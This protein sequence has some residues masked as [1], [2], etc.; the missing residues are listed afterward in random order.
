MARV[1]IVTGSGVITV[2]KRPLD[3]Y[4]ALA[5]YRQVVRQP[6]VVCGCEAKYDIFVNLNGGGQSGQAGAVRHGIARSLVKVNEADY[7]KL[8]KTAGLLTR[9]PR[10]KE[11]K[12]YG[13]HKAR[14]A[15]QFS[16]R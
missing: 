6:L 2:N 9:D 5:T 7:K 3:E 13:L 8:L 1:R 11:R 12:K 10:A 15:S 4:F 14:K 16:K